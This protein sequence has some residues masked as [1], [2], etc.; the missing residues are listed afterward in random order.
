MNPVAPVRAMSVPLEGTWLLRI[1][2]PIRSL[3]NTYSADEPT[4]TISHPERL[5][6]A[7]WTASHAVAASLGNSYVTSTSEAFPPPLMV[8]YSDRGRNSGDRDYRDRYRPNNDRAG[9]FEDRNGDG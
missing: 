2:G 9:G 6:K 4:E 5:A 7:R 8:Q 1:L 3:W